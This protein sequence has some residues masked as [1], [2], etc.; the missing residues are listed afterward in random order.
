MAES[1]AAAPPTQAM[2][3]LLATVVR[4]CSCVRDEDPPDGLPA[5]GVLREMAME[6]KQELLELERKAKNHG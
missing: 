1:T 3:K 5:A 6:A 2:L 4:A